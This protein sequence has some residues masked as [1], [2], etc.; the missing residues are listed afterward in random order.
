MNL[1]S[2]ER[3]Q[4]YCAVEPENYHPYDIVHKS[5]GNGSK[6][7]KIKERK[8]LTRAST[9]P[10]QSTVPPEWPHSGELLFQ[11]VSLRYPTSSRAV[12]R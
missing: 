11:N 5:N 9:V 12:L 10:L 3:I 8:S 2:V 7:D 4:E 1:N 6:S